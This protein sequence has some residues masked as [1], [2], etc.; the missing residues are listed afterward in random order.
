[1]LLSGTTGGAS[2]VSS[3]GFG[4]LVASLC[5]YDIYFKVEGVKNWDGTLKVIRPPRHHHI[6]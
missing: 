1:M 4:F 2:F 5:A 3:V 6:A